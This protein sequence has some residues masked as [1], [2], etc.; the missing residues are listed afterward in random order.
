M[1]LLQANSLKFRDF[2]ELDL[3]EYAILSHTW[4]PEEEVSL[5]DMCSPYLPTKKCYAKV[6]K[7]CRLALR[8]NIEFVWVDTC[9][10]DKSSSAELT[11]SINS[12]FRWYQNA[13]VCYV[14]LADLS[15]K[16]GIEEGLGMCRWFKRGW[17]LQEL[18]API[19]VQFYD[20]KWKYRGSKSD[21]AADISKITGIPELAI[22][23]QASLKDFSTAQRMAWASQ[24]ETTR[25]EDIAY[26]LLGLFD[27]NMPLIYGEGSRAFRRLQE[28]IIRQGIDLTLFSR[29][30]C[31]PHLQGSYSS[32]LASSPAEFQQ[33]DN[34]T[35]RKDEPISA[36][37]ITNKGLQISTFLILAPMA[38]GG[39]G[40]DDVARYVLRLGQ[41]R[42]GIT[43]YDVGIYLK[44]IGPAL[45]V[46]ETA[47]A[48]ANILE[49]DRKSYRS[50]RDHTFCI[51]T[52]VPPRGFSV[53]TQMRQL[54]AF[55]M[56]MHDQV[57]RIPESEVPMGSWDHRTRICF[58]PLLKTTVVAY[59][60]TASIRKTSLG[61][62]VLLDFRDW[63]RRNPPRCLVIDKRTLEARIL[64]IVLQAKT[65]E[66][67]DWRAVEDGLPGIRQLT[68]HLY[69]NIEGR[70]IEIVAA[71][72][73]RTIELE[74]RSTECPVLEIEIKEV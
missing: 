64:F 68:D 21:F 41:I 44:K 20:H 65:V 34:I 8:D 58:R 14:Y 66:P 72:N 25:I 2:N 29:Q 22:V 4:D 12:M 48:L 42:N 60:F 36:Y 61:L 51:L 33:C 69:I 67:I 31:H 24:R 37:T 26:C 35:P 74:S 7:T 1:R 59:S 49:S 15:A 63:S 38:L 43:V 30:P 73:E 19:D 32:L 45:L 57:H 39:Q 53:D 18:L 40:V 17:T 56:P 16:T 28:E 50:T 23:G 55:Y 11:E 52:T 71:I 27:V 5:Q 10:I 9:C 13:K 70:G 46:R 62:G 54:P 6:T 3:P 47:S